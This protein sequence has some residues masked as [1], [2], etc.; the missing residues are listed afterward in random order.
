MA[1]GAGGEVAHPLTTDSVARYLRG[2]G[3]S[4]RMMR[5]DPRCAKGYD[6]VDFTDDFPHFLKS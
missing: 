4:P 3:I 6:L 5:I 2:F 1:V